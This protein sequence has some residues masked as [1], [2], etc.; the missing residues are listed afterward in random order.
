MGVYICPALPQLI[1]IMYKSLVAFSF[2]FLV[3][4]HSSAQIIIPGNYQEEY[5]GLLNLKNYSS[6]SS[7][8]IFPT[9][10]NFFTQRDSLKWNIWDSN[11]GIE[12]FNDKKISFSNLSFLSAVNYTTPWSYNDGPIWRGKGNNVAI[13]AGVNYVTD[14]FIVRFNPIL[15]YAQNKPYA[16]PPVAGD[17][18]EF[19][20]PLAF[21]LDYV[22]RYGNDAFTKLYPGQSEIRFIVKKMTVGLSTQNMS[23]GPS[24][25]NPILMSKQAAGFPHIDLGTFV[26]VSTKIGTIEGKSYW[27]LLSESDY[28]D[29][30]SDNDRRLFGGLVLAYRPSFL[31]SLNVGITRSLYRNFE[32]VGVSDFFAQFITLDNSLDEPVGGAIT[33][34]SYDQMASVFASW[35]FPE[36]GFEAYFEFAKNDFPG[37]FLEFVRYPD[38]ARAYTFGFQK[39][40][41]VKE[42]VLKIGYEGTVLSAN[43]IKSITGRGNPTYYVH[44]LIPQGYTHDGQIIG[45]GIGPGSNSNWVGFQ[46]YTPNS[47]FGL[48]AERIRFNDDYLINTYGGQNPAP[49]EYQL[50]YVA[51]AVHHLSQF[52]FQGRLI[53]SRHSNLYTD[54]ER[55]GETLNFHVNID[56]RF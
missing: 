26:P 46:F 16:I 22:Q 43:Q 53:Y 56:Y 33:N 34:D 1:L 2:L 21:R 4:F 10:T 29:D 48:E 3:G 49:V 18:S 7:I 23:W 11:F 6:S 27:G 19:S 35:V 52:S 24:K 38:R 14:H 13:T 31:K 51:S 40:V 15:T 9:I 45:A 50:N 36:Q 55:G 44:F 12:E 54:D 32:G 25:R 17:K 8:G 28:F 20:Y 41:D 5:V 42:N 39:L 47:S 37:N 30:N